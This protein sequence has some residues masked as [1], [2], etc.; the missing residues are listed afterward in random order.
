[1]AKTP[2]LNL[3]KL[4]QRNYIINGNFDFW[5][6]NTTFSSIS[7]EVYTADRW[8]AGILGT[9]TMNITRNADVPANTSASFSFNAEVATAQ[10]SF[11]GSQRAGIYQRIEG[12]N[13]RALKNSNAT[14]SFWVKS[15]TIGTY[16][17]S[18]GN[19]ASDRTWVSTYTINS[20]GTWE[21]KSVRVN[22]KSASG[23]WD[24]STGVGTFIYFALASG[25]TVQTSNLD[26]WNNSLFISSNTQVNMMATSGNYIRL[27]QIQ[28]VEGDED[29]PFR[30][31]GQNIANELLLCQRYFEKSYDLDNPIGSLTPS[32]AI[33]GVSSSTSVGILDMQVA[34]KNN[35]RVSP[36]VAIYSPSAGT[37]GFL[38]RGATPLAAGPL[39]TNFQGF[40]I[41]NSV[42]TIA[43]S[44]HQAHW[45]A[46][47]EL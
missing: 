26:A 18:I 40:C 5:Q 44:G 38:D 42:L 47:A 12:S 16:S 30:L 32:G 39:N 34:F 35:K 24:F 11:T 19:S 45:T 37:V 9:A 41:T 4:F 14:L 2:E 10:V 20:P 43:S 25:S 28:L 13:F 46:D 1:M 15:S 17:V 27:S 29:I 23:T 7:T 3:E 6:R 33:Y 31:A 8:I 21:K 22:F 36:V